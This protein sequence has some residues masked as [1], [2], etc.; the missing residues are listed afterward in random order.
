MLINLGLISFQ[1][2]LKYNDIFSVSV[3]SSTRLHLCLVGVIF[4]LLLAGCSSFTDNGPDQST[5]TPTETPSESTPSAVNP[6]GEQAVSVRIA[7]DATVKNLSRHRSALREAIRWHNDAEPAEYEIQLTYTAD[8]SADLTI[9]PSETIS[10]C[11]YER[12]TD[13][14]LFC[15]PQYDAGENAPATDTIK[16][17]TRYEQPTTETFYREALSYLTGTDHPRE[18]GDIQRPTPVSVRDP[19]PARDTV[20]VN[21]SDAP[22][23]DSPQRVRQVLE[24]WSTGEGAQYRNYSQEFVLRPDAEQAAVTVNYTNDIGRCGFTNQSDIGGC[25]PTLSGDRYASDHSEIRIETGYVADSR[26][27]ILIH[28]FGHLYG[29]LHGQSP[30]PEMN[31]TIDLTQTATPNATARDQPW[32][33][34]LLR[35]YLDRQS[36]ENRD[37]DIDTVERELGNSFEAL[38]DD[39]TV[40]PEEVRFERVDE[41]DQADIIITINELDTGTGSDSTL[42][43]S[44]PDADTALEEYTEL[45]ITLGARTPAEDYGYHMA[46]WVIRSFVDE[47]PGHIDADGNDDREGWEETR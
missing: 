42:Y 32:R 6:W 36:V 9:E 31:A 41:R 23:S 12:T 47:Q 24:Y 38:E 28:E 14:F 2:T 16:I 25:A 10:Q 21:I 35:V 26:E 3:F 17:T 4:L 37:I 13:S 46:Y 11:G 30:S 40:I 20:V 22:A 44:D 7:S 34:D 39:V 15:S 27:Q 8:E 5:L 29:R 33:N 19:W 45:Y 43:G 18:R 1:L